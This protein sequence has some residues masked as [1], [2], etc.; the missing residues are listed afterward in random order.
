MYWC[1]ISGYCNF[2]GFWSKISEFSILT[3][4][5]KIYN[6]LGLKPDIGTGDEVVA[7]TEAIIELEFTSSKLSLG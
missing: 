4:Y 5:D 7:S 1:I 6:R 3:G 2:S